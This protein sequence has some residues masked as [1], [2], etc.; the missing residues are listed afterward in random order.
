LK[1]DLNAQSTSFKEEVSWMAFVPC[2]NDGMGEWVTGTVVLH[3]VVHSN[4]RGMVTKVHTQPQVTNLVGAVTGMVYKGN[5]VT[6][7][8]YDSNLGDN[9]FT[10]TYIN[11]YHIV[12]QG[13][14]YHVKVTE[15]LTINANGELTVQ[16]DNISTEC[17]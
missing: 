7:T 17:K 11:R 5:G 8:M 2:A 12:G 1:N 3:T 6:Q 15:H 10:Q 4:K 14:Q 9:A 16:V 13:I